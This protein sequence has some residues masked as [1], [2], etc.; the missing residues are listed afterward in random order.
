MRRE[1]NNVSVIKIP[2]NSDKLFGYRPGRNGRRFVL[3][4][5]PASESY[6]GESTNRY[7]IFDALLEAEENALGDLQKFKIR[8]MMKCM[9]QVHQDRLRRSSDWDVLDELEDY[10]NPWR[11]ADY[12]LDSGANA[13]GVK[14]II[15]NP[16]VQSVFDSYYGLGTGCFRD[17]FFS[18]TVMLMFDRRTSELHFGGSDLLEFIESDCS[19]EFAFSDN[20]CDSNEIITRHLNHALMCNQIDM[21][22]SSHIN[23]SVS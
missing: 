18:G 14:S 13:D 17:L 2:K 3:Y 6:P 22:A 7:N 23:Y 15:N 4:Y 5:D 9:E 20:D 19:K 1:H 10:D 8:K 21:S 16:R 11:I 12:S